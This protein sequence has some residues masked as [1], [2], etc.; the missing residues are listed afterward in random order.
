MSIMWFYEFGDN[1]FL[2]KDMV[3]FFFIVKCEMLLLLQKRNSL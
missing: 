3:C 1:T 2:T